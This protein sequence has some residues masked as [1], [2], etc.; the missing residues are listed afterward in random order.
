MRRSLRLLAF[1]LVERLD[2]VF[3]PVVL[4]LLAARRGER[5]RAQGRAGGSIVDDE[6]AGGG[7]GDAALTRP[8]ARRDRIL[9]LSRERYG[10]ERPRR[11]LVEIHGRLVA[12]V[13]ADVAF[14]GARLGGPADDAEV[15]LGAS[16]LGGDAGL[17]ELDD[18]R[19]VQ[20]EQPTI[21]LGGGDRFDRLA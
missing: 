16:Q 20:D 10:E 15:R 18:L 13:V 12:H 14:V 5:R 2:A 17:R 1:L 11:E 7:S 9:A 6:L 3:D 19:R 4:D 8:V 21:V